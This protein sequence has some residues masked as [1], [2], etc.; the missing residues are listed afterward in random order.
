MG[1]RIVFRNMII[2][3]IWKYMNR[4]FCHIIRFLAGTLKLWKVSRGHANTAGSH[5]SSSAGSTGDKG[6]GERIPLPCSTSMEKGRAGA[7]SD[8]KAWNSPASFSSRF[9][10]TSGWVKSRSSRQ[11]RNSSNEY[12][13][14]RIWARRPRWKTNTPIKSG[15]GQVSDQIT[16][17]FS[18]WLQSKIK[19][20]YEGRLK[21][22]LSYTFSSGQVQVLWQ[23]V[24]ES[25]SFTV[26]N[27]RMALNYKNYIW[28][29]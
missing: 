26:E 20:H 22:I 14:T 3:W 23:K 1:N 18:T 29:L 10:A 19:C 7:S 5:N 11:A 6:A 13:N 8:R 9:S 16:S 2:V 28:Q 12:R 21:Y 17:L 25:V 27:A 15:F 24:P 4:T